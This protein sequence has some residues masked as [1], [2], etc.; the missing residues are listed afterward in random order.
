MDTTIKRV[1]KR[2]LRYIW[3][4][5]L[6]GIAVAALYAIPKILHSRQ[7]HSETVAT[8]DI[9]QEEIDYSAN[10]ESNPD[11]HRVAVYTV[12][13][14]P[15]L[16]TNSKDPSNPG[17]FLWNYGN[18]IRE[19]TIS[20]G[21]LS[22]VYSSLIRQFDILA[23]QFSIYNMQNE[24]ITIYMSDSCTLFLAVDSPSDL[25]KS[26]GSLFTDKDL[27]SIRDYVFSGLVKSIEDS[28]YIDSL[29]VRLKRASKETE[30]SISMTDLV[31]AKNPGHAEEDVSQG[32]SL[33]RTLLFGVFGFAVAYAHCLLFCFWKEKDQDMVIGE[34]KGKSEIAD[35]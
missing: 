27:C 5:V 19:Y 31:R 22:A 33:K 11:A 4:P 20:Y 15:E 10:W 3:I 34:E 14:Q 7:N 23:S 26:D 2:S 13:I 35:S 6:I 29:P 8:T 25:C 12:E 21:Q 17:S 16:V 1:F 32:L 24:M 18:L 28:E 30:D 9:A